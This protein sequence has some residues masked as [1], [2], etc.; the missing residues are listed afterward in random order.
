MRPRSTRKSPMASVALSLWC[1]PSPNTTTSHPQRE[2]V[3]EGPSSRV[4]WAP[5]AGT[6]NSVE[7]SPVERSSSKRYVHSDSGPAKQAQHHGRAPPNLQH[8]TLEIGALIQV[9]SS[10]QD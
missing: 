8:S 9:K 1:S 7:P 6:G 10:P 4:K 2:A 3:S 5:G